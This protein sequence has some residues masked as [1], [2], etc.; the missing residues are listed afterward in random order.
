MANAGNVLPGATPPGGSDACTGSTG[1]KPPDISNMTLKE[2]FTRLN[3]RIMQ[4]AGRGDTSCVIRFWPM[5]QGAYQNLLPGDRDVDSRYH[6][7]TL[8]L[9]LGQTKEANALADTIMK[10]SPDNLFGYYVRANAAGVD[11]DSTVAQGARAAF[12]A[13]FDAEIRKTRPEYTDHRAF[14]DDY[15][16]GEGA[17]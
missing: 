13:H 14:L 10:E 5:A 8:F 15:K 12:R 4:A 2:Q 3:D 7:A 17:H 9:L 6:M 16:K 11:G 1:G